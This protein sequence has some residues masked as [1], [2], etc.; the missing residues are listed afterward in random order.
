[1]YKEQNNHN[2]LANSTHTDTEAK[3]IFVTNINFSEKLKA[4]KGMEGGHHTPNIKS[5]KKKETD[6][7]YETHPLHFL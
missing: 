6:T 4:T 7:E 1:M 2:H 3:N 5:K